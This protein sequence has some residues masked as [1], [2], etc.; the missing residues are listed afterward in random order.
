MRRSYRSQTCCW[1]P[2]RRR[3][4]LSMPSQGQEQCASTGYSTLEGP[5]TTIQAI[6]RCVAPL[7]F[8]L[9]AN[10]KSMCMVPTHRTRPWQTQTDHLR[11][12]EER[13]RPYRCPFWLTWC[14]KSR[15]LGYL[16]VQSPTRETQPFSTEKDTYRFSAPQDLRVPPASA[17]RVA[18]GGSGAARCA[19][20]LWTVVVGCARVSQRNHRLLVRLP[21]VVVKHMRNLDHESVKVHLGS[22]GPRI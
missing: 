13:S 14:E 15:A 19:S 9:Q 10:S 5:R 3:D 8:L 22:Y 1:A 2:F 17:A 21:G 12:R 11:E 6:C 20:A 4:A 7:R 16:V 18:G